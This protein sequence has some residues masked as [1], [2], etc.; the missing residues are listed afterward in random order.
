MNNMKHNLFFSCSA[1]CL[2]LLSACVENDMKI[3]TPG[4]EEPEARFLDAI[5][6]VFAGAENDD[7]EIPTITPD[8]YIDNFDDE[9]LQDN[10]RNEEQTPEDGARVDTLFFSQLVSGK[11]V[12]FQGMKPENFPPDMPERMREKYGQDGYPNLYKYYYKKPNYEITWEDDPGG[13]NFFPTDTV[14]KMNWDDIKFWGLNNTGYVL[15]GLYYPYNNKLPYDENGNVDFKVEAEQTSKDALRKS[16]FLGAYHSSSKSGQRLKFKLY[17]LAAYL[18]VTLY[19]PVFN[20]NDTIVDAKGDTITGA[21]TG[22][23]ADAL[24]KAEVRNVYNH[25]RINWYGGRSS[26]AAPITAVNKD[27]PRTNITMYMPEADEY[28]DTDGLP[29]VEKIYIPDY[30]RN[31]L[32][33]PMFK[34]YDNCWKI[35]LTALI[36]GG[37]DYPIGD[38]T[39]PTGQTWTDTNFLRFYIRQNIGDEPLRYVFTGKSANGLIGSGDNINISQGSLQHLNLYLPR[40]GARAILLNASVEDWEQWYNDNMGLRQE[41]PLKPSTPDPDTDPDNPDSGEPGS[42]DASS[43]S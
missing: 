15:Y 32:D 34:E 21:R 8:D 20:P 24:L 4:Q 33:D 37:Q 30:V 14:T 3:S 42:G 31:A 23:P 41:D 5:G 25:F 10:F 17:H 38:E 29:P 2:A 6:A 28:A 43:N 35:T 16:N 36:P 19:I 40:Y 26:D 39:Y 13:Y 22:F 27:F 12:P 1:L 18:K 7:I 11:L 9:I